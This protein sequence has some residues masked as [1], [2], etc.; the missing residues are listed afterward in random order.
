MVNSNLKL[1][2][3]K[4]AQGV[5][6]RD[7]YRLEKSLARIKQRISQN[8]PVSK[9]LAKLSESI[10]ESLGWIAQRHKQIP[11]IDYPQLPIAAES[12]HIKKLLSENQVIV[13]AGETGSGKTTQLPKICLELGLG[14]RG[15]IGHTQPRRVAARSVA[16]RIAEE[17]K[18]SL[19]SLVGYQVR[20]TDQ[21]GPNTL[22]KLMTDGILL[23]EIQ[24]DPYLRNYECII[25]DEAHERS[26]NI[27]FLLGYL[28]QLLPKRPDL[29]LII[30]SATIDVDRFSEHFDSAPV[31]QVSGRTFP[32]EI[33]YRPWED[34]Y[35]SPVDAVLG[36]VKEIIETEPLSHEASDIL[37]FCTG[38]RDI[39]EL[40][41]ALRRAHLKNLDILPLYSRLS[42]AEQ[43]RVFKTGRGRR[44]VLAT[45]VAETSLTV[46]GIGFVI[47]TGT[48]RISRYSVRTKVQRLP[49]E[50]I[51]Q[52]SANQ[53]AGRCGRIA[54]G[55]CIRLYSEQDFSSR[56]K[57]TAPEI[58][59]TNL[60]AVILQMQSLKLGDIADF[61]FVE[62]P[63][64]KQVRDGLRLLEELSLVDA[65]DHITKLGQ[66]LSGLPVDPRFARILWQAQKDQCL[67]EAI[68]IVSALSIQ[69]PR[70][71][72][73]DKQQQADEKHRVFMDKESDFNAI[74][75]LWNAYQDNRQALS[76]RKLDD[77]C[78][79][80]FLSPLRM[81]EWREVHFQLSLMARE[82]RWKLNKNPPSYKCLHKALLSGLI[83]QIGVQQENKEFLGTRNRRFRV[84][85]GSHL[86]RKPPKWVFAAQMLDT[87]QLF[88]HQVAK[89]NPEWLLGIADHA[90]QTDYYE[91]YY[92]ARRGEIMA[93]MRYSLFGL[94]V[95]D[96]HKVSY[97]SIEPNL[98][99][100]LFV[101][102]ALANWKYRGRGRF[103]RHNREVCERL[104]ELED[105]TRSGELLVDEEQLFQFYMGRIPAEVNDQT[106]FETWRSQ[107]EVDNPQILLLDEDSLTASVDQ[108]KLVEFPDTLDWQGL[109]FRLSY[110]FQPGSEEDGVTLHVPVDQLHQ[111]PEHLVEWLVP[112]LLKDKLVAVLKALPKRYR[113]ELVPISA[114]VDKIWPSMTPGNQP[115]LDALSHQ[116]KRSMGKALPEDSWADITL[117]DF[118]LMRYSLEDD[119]GRCLA[120][121]RNLKEL[122]EKYRL[123]AQEAISDI[124][125]D[126]QDFPDASSWQFGDLPDFVDIKKGKENVRLWPA[127]EDK[128]DR[129]GYSLKDNVEEARYLH[130]K[131]VQRLFLLVQPDAGKYLRKELFKSAD[132]RLM[133]L[134]NPTNEIQMTLAEL[135]EDLVMAV[136]QD[137]LP[138]AFGIRSP[139]AFQEE[140]ERHRGELVRRAL[141]L[142]SLCLDWADQLRIVKSEM[143]ALSAD[144]DE[145]I[146][147]INTQLTDLFAKHFLQYMPS[148]WQQH[149]G[150]YLKG[151]S[152][153]I[154]RMQGQLPRDL[155]MVAEITDMQNRYRQLVNEIPIHRRGESS[156]LIDLRWLLE[157]YRISL[158]SQ[159]IKTS[160]PVSRKRLEN[161]FE[162]TLKA[163]AT[164]REH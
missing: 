24:R 102:E 114:H 119:D 146:A 70:E 132:L 164:L 109:G 142:E 130:S 20:F 71:R 90:L 60:A 64:D 83:T 89:V 157:E 88:A 160:R 75:N 99:H 112:G 44:V 62:R 42:I 116:L 93:R 50:P 15:L 140:V 59:R 82:L 144:F 126:A 52:A 14:T 105:R 128:F 103:L 161:H 81:R 38:E 135:K 31:V 154:D 25:I 96:Q 121:S 40:A 94:I 65:D 118:Y 10:E 1:I 110:K 6:G 37:V 145:A 78:R 19:G 107:A 48:A 147:D 57:F 5:S 100:E 55:I 3:E 95:S 156:E 97:K 133:T 101:R 22:V 84:F 72:P 16:A 104:Q 152:K 117:D 155:E 7:Q 138:E 87:S 11:Q 129:V 143:A 54:D 125:A 111:V 58:M 51:S 13:V 34:E 18:T 115:L 149:V 113:R 8:K 79:K 49:I 134:L 69:D 67:T 127:L 56:D 53:R 27:D 139:E 158:F 35:D 120:S 122:R 141:E 74:L 123:Q 85:P 76:N 106:T 66:L 91:P 136:A 150:R 153:R 17:L 21:S 92:H 159:P 39:R 98:C 162:M 73:A 23:S 77:W 124:K 46:P 45:N 68:T 28:K 30:T 26:I 29:K 33:F 163:T 43:D 2:E 36:Q 151:I 80:H 12:T 41:L 47:D 108:D 4:L 137:I 131:G 86:A 32:V 9:D 148:E 63:Q 61:P